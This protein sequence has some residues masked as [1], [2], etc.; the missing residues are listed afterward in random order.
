MKV[1]M[2]RLLKVMLWSK[3]RPTLADWHVKRLIPLNR[4]YRINYDNG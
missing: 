3:N 1:D 2:V 4:F